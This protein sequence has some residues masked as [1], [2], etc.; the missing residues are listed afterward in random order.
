MYNKHEMKKLSKNFS[1]NT[2]ID[3]SCRFEIP[4]HVSSSTELHANCYFDSYFFI[5]SGSIIYSNTRFGKFCTIAR[6]CEIGVAGHP[7]DWL[8]SHS[9]QYKYFT[10]CKFEP[11]LTTNIGN[12]VWIGSKVIVKSGVTIADGAIVAAG[13][14]VVKDIPPYA[15]VGGTPAKVIK[16]RFSSH[17]IQRLLKVKWWDIPISK[18]SEV[19]F[20]DIEDA[21]SKIEEL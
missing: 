18:L 6:N 13:S 2:Y 17:I 3:E 1:K 7:T 15:I 20:D 21:L 14:V 12:D 5:N 19:R 16:Y 8:S 4:S 9:F 11:N 10:D